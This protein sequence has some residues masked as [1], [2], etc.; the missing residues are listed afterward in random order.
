MTSSAVTTSNIPANLFSTIA[1]DRSRID[2]QH[3]LGGTEARL[4]YSFIN[5][6]TNC[7]GYHNFCVKLVLSCLSTSYKMVWINDKSGGAA[8]GGRLWLRRLVVNSLPFLFFIFCDDQ[9][10][11]RNYT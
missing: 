7:G 11:V 6:L 9:L 3:S 1:V 5:N 8:G 4:Y 2:R 10:C